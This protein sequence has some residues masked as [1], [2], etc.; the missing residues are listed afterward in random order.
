MTA[1]DPVREGREWL[2]GLQ[3]HEDL[4]RSE[5]YRLAERL[6]SG[7][8]PEALAGA[9][10]VALAAKGESPEEI[11][12]FAT[13]LRRHAR[14][15]LPGEVDGAVDLCGTGG[16]AHPTF[17]VSTVSAFVVAAGGLPV[18]KHGNSSARGP[19]GSSDLLEALGLPVK[20]SP[21]Y[22]EASF[23]RERLAFLHAPLYHPATASIAGIR[24]ALGT[25]TVFNLLGPL[26]NPAPVRIQLL[27]CF[28][29]AYARTASGL[30]PRLGVSRSLT[31]TGEE[32][33]DEFV[34]G[35]RTFGFVRQG[36]R[37][38]RCR[39]EGRRYLTPRERRGSIGPLPPTGAARE[40]ERLLAG[41]SGARRGSVLLTAGAAFWVSGQDRT[42]NEGVERARRLLD[43]GKA[44]E[45]LRALQ[46]LAE[47][48]TWS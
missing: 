27:G 9:L 17:N 31:F 44:L 26:S 30:L 22:A 32:G 10:L 42:M 20:V 13:F 18:V 29:R 33:T 14:A 12:A 45:K 38:A 24:R 16:A 25:R 1:K 43:E 46:E 37:S 41:G 19:C 34:P 28:D 8:F 2:L 48:R 36:E 40:A 39:F 47:G 5:A 7:T 23:R 11:F 35:G 4:S 15:F 6:A 21:G 3:H